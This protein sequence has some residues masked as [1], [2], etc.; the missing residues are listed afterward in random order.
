SRG[1]IVLGVEPDAGYERDFEDFVPGATLVLY[2]DGITEAETKRGGFFGLEALERLLRKHHDASA[3][4]L[5]DIVFDALERRCVSP[6]QDDQT[7][8]VVK[9][10]PR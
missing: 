10:E 9:R 8:L 3:E 5:V 6:R 7:L 1:G 4:G 2:S